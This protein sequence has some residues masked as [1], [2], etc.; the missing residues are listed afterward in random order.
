MISAWRKVFLLLAICMLTT[1]AAA[2]SPGDY[3]YYRDATVPPFQKSREFFSM[4]KRP[5]KYE[6]SLISE[7]IGPLTFRILRVH[8]EQEHTLQQMRSY[9]ISNHE[10]HANFD[11]PSGKDHLVVEIANSNPLLNAKV[12]VYVVEVAQH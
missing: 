5:G 6:I 3:L 2:D 11:N 12:S 4:P 8:N 10:F 9:N 1:P 7:S